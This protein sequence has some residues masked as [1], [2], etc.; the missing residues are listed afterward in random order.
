MNITQAHV[1]ITYVKACTYT[2][3]LAVW[4]VMCVSDCRDEGP[5]GVA[6]NPCV[7]WVHWYHCSPWKLLHIA[8]VP[9]EIRG[10]I[11]RHANPQG[12]A[13]WD[14]LECG[15]MAKWLY[16]KGQDQRRSEE[17][18]AV[19]PAVWVW[20]LKLQLWCAERTRIP[21]FMSYYSLL[22]VNNKKKSINIY[23]VCLN[24]QVNSNL[25]FLTG[26]YL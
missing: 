16:I 25:S 13:S 18:Q 26:Y 19:T 1:V 5:L 3:P 21:G 20:D 24:V 22:F 14:D 10:S 6:G 9:H 8:F 11:P 17:G 4:K 23:Y 2:L 12:R 7:L 15:C